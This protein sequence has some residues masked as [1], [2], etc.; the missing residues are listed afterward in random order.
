MQQ[1]AKM[2]MLGHSRRCPPGRHFMTVQRK[3]ISTVRQPT[4]AALNLEAGTWAAVHQMKT[5]GTHVSTGICRWQTTSVI[6]LQTSFQARNVLSRLRCRDTPCNFSKT[7]LNLISDDNRLEA[8]TIVS[9]CNKPAP[10]LVRPYTCQN[11]HSP[12]AGV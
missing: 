2:M 1:P 4:R 6:T 7:L 12:S 5:S 3:M 8:Y 11:L 10:L 9:K